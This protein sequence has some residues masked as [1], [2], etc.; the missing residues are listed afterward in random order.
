MAE[1]LD[2]QGTPDQTPQEP[3]IDTATTNNQENLEPSTKVLMGTDGF[4]AGTLIY[5]ADGTEKKIEDIELGDI[6]YGYNVAAKENIEHEVTEFIK[7][8]NDFFVKYTFTNGT[9][10]SCTKSQPLID[11]NLEILSHLP[12]EA[13]TKHDFRG[14][15]IGKLEGGTKVV[16]KNG[17]AEIASIEELPNASTLT[18]NLA[19]EGSHNFFANGILVSDKK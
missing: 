4:P 6:V 3:V 8:F 14:R 2:Q 19:I 9:S 15:Y 11:V 13:D 10:L 18:F 16:T 1:E 12:E 17:E 7:P 5:M